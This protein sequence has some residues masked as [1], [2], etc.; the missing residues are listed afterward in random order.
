[1]DQ[2]SARDGGTAFCLRLDGELT[3][4]LDE[5]RRRQPEILSKSASAREL[6]ARALSFDSPHAEGSAVRGSG[7]G[8]PP[9]AR[10]AG[11]KAVES[12]GKQETMA[13]HA[14]RERGRVN[15]EAFGLAVA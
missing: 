7:G 8:A 14:T 15:R 2:E 5:W 9:A 4:Q 13:P 3:K 6:I 12:E 11:G 10:T 1:M